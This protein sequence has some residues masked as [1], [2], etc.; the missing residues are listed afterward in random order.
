MVVQDGFSF[1]GAR[2][3]SSLNFPGLPYLVFRV[4][5]SKTIRTVPFFAKIF[6]RKVALKKQY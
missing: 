2:S 3:G 6:S 1:M 4:Q 5:A